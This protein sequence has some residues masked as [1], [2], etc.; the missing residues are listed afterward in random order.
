[1]R[2]AIIGSTGQLGTDLAKVLQKTGSYQVIPLS[3]DVV[4]CTNLGSVKVALT[5]LHPEIV[6]NCAAYVRVDECEERPEEAF[7]VNA[8]GALHIARVSAELNALCVYIG[9]DYVFDGEKRRGFIQ[10]KI[11]LIR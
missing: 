5:N 7:R 2:V 4:E 6:V 1:M 8:L 10:K 9:T 3:H 11:S